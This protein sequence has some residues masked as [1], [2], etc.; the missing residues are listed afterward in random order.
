MQVL[1]CFFSLVLI[2]F[3]SGS[4]AGTDF[5]KGF[6]VGSDLSWGWGSDLGSASGVSEMGSGSAVGS[7][8]KYLRMR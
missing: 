1:P 7:V 8:M 3:G 4:G 5:D 2:L 6:E